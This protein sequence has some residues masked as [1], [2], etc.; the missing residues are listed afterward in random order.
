MSAYGGSYGLIVSENQ[1]SQRKSY[2]W[3]DE[4]TVNNLR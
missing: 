3:H 4:L 2:R 1:I